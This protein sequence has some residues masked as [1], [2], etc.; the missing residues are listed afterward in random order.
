MRIELLL[1]SRIAPAVVVVIEEAEGMGE[2]LLFSEVLAQVNREALHLQLE[3]V[4]SF[5][6]FVTTSSVP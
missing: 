4:D 2:E 3:S 1:A 6:W 5:L